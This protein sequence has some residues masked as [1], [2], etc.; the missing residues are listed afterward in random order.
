MD[1]EGFPGGWEAGAP[2]SPALDAGACVCSQP[3]RW[4]RQRARHQL[5]PVLFLLLLLLLV[6]PQML[7]VPLGLGSI[8]PA[9][10]TCPSVCAGR[11]VFISTA[12][13]GWRVAVLR[14]RCALCVFSETERKYC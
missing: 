10:R 5:L 8:C 11:W 13:A 9:G 12:T 14:A 6:L 3:A 7:W 4:G 1:E 2:R